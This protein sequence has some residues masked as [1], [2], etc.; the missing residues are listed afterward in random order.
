MFMLRSDP[1]LRHA[2]SSSTPPLCPPD[3]TTQHISLSAHCRVPGK[4]ATPPVH[5][6]HQ[7]TPN[8]LS[9]RHHGHVPVVYPTP[10]FG[11]FCSCIRALQQPTTPLA[12]SLSLSRLLDPLACRRTPARAD[13]TE[14]SARPPWHPWMCASLQN[15][16]STHTTPSPRYATTPPSQWTPRAP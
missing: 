10:P 6:R 2:T 9:A 13:V 15:A 4:P 16:C 1:R 7:S 11:Q 5:H 8:P 3:Q 12:Q 14:R